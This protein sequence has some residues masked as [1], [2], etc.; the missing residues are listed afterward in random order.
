MDQNENNQWHLILEYLE[1]HD[2][3]TPM[4]AMFELSIM[5]LSTRIGELERCGYVFEREFVNDKNKYGKPIH[6][7]KYRLRGQNG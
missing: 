2:S 6:Y 5:K 3:I 1:T 7:M 4:E